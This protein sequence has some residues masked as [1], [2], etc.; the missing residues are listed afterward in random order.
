MNVKGI[1]SERLTQLREEKGLT[2]QKMADDLK[3]SRASLEYY[4]KGKRAPDIET[5]YEIAEYFDISADYL[6][7]RTPNK[8]TNPELK[9]VCK[10]T[11]LSD[12]TCYFLHR[13]QSYA[14]G[15][16]MTQNYYEIVENFGGDDE[17][18][19]YLKKLTI[20]EA[21]QDISAIN[22]I[23]TSEKTL[24]LLHYLSIFLYT[25]FSV[26]ENEN[27]ISGI[28]VDESEKKGGW[29]LVLSAP[30]LENGVLTEIINIIRTLKNGD[31]SVFQLTDVEPAFCRSEYS[32]Q[33]EINP[34]DPMINKKPKGA[35]SDGKHNPS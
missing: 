3:I 35:E 21:H 28:I 32:L 2:R 15:Q 16:T 20:E 7:G 24:D 19:E 23:L 25:N 10:Y 8:T 18:A 27:P 34:A 12:K 31:E 17:D 4:E 29:F 1:F 5:L 33:H 6:L 26:A 30:I 22:T 14:N 11:G 9:S 13:L